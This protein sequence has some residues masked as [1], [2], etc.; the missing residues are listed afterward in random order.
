MVR[1]R[2][3]DKQGDGHHDASGRRSLGGAEAF[4]QQPPRRRALGNV[5][6]GDHREWRIE[7]RGKRKVIETDD[8]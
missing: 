6:S 8:G 2:P 3:A 4:D 7:Q 5:R 1:R